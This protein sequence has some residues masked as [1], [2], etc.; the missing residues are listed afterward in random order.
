MNTVMINPE[1]PHYFMYKKKPVLLITSA[2]HYGA[3]INLGF[4]YIKYF[5]TLKKNQLNYT[6]IYPG[7]YLEIEGMFI[8]NNTLAPGQ[9]ALIVPWSRSSVPGY[10]GGGNKFDLSKWDEKYFRRLKDFLTQAAARDIIVE[11]CFFNCQ[12]P[13]T[14]KY[15]PLYSDCNIQGIGKCDYADFQTLKEETLVKAQEVYIRKIV[16]E[17]NEFDNVIFEICDEPTLHGTPSKLASEWIGRMV[18][19]IIATELPMPKKHLIAQQLEIGVDF[20]R[21]ERVQVIV[22][23][24]VLY[25]SARQI[26]GMMALDC[27]Y[28]SNK[29]IELNETAYFPIW[30]EGDRIASSRIEAWEFIIGG[31]A[32]FNQLNGYFT[33]VDPC[34]NSPENEAVL[35]GLQNLRKFMNLFDYVKMTRSKDFIKK[36]ADNN[37]NMNGIAETGKQYALYIHHGYLGLGYRE[38]FSYIAAQG[39]YKADITLDLPQGEYT[40]EWYDPAEM[41]LILSE[42]LSHEYGKVNLSGPEYTMDIALKIIAEE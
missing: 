2:E 37:T 13:E 1:N 40:V 33:A 8:E 9:D 22:S 29:P 27:E 7:A 35:K 12:Y 17:S 6:R 24:Y 20:S 36:S 39:N 11:I 18:D 21:D 10:A 14:R 32:G 38:P 31:G 26:G 42:K 30:Y 15:S 28:S 41:R 25:V 5:D 19:V 16:Q 4:D 3:L 34:G 23:Q